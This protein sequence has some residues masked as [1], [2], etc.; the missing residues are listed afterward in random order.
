M[1]TC[2]PNLT[3]SFLI[4]CKIITFKV[5]NKSFFSLDPKVLKAKKT[6]S[7]NRYGMCLSTFL[8]LSKLGTCLQNLIPTR[9]VEHW[10]K[11][12]FPTRGYAKIHIQRPFFDNKKDIKKFIVLKIQM[13]NIYSSASSTHRFFF[14]ETLKSQFLVAFQSFSS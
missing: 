5:D 6:I 4:V 1:S 2:P 3:H 9:G 12:H 14:L 11:N 13:V 7:W 10:E 8:F